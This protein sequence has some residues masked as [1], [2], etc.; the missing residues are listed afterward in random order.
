MTRKFQ[1]TLFTL[2]ALSAGILPGCNRSLFSNSDS[3]T[4]DRLDR[5]YGGDSATD[6]R[7]TRSKA[8]EMGFGFPT[9]MAN[10]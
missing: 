2:I 6:A 4:H 1:W 7:A 9:G 10:Q 3:Y 5:Y 8:S